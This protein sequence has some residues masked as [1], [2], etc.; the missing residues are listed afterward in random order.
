MRLNNLLGKSI[1]NLLMKSTS[2]DFQSFSL[3]VRSAFICF[4]WISYSSKVCFWENSL[5]WT[6]N[7]PK[8]KTIKLQFFFEQLSG[9]RTLGAYKML[10]DRTFD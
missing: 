9:I 4:K 8:S 10:N 6:T 1:W 5:L 3:E 2:E 7:F